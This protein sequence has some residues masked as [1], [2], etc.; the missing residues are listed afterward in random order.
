MVPA[1]EKEKGDQDLW[2]SLFDQESHLSPFAAMLVVQR[3]A[4]EERPALAMVDLKEAVPMGRSGPQMQSVRA[5]Y[6]VKA[7]S[8]WEQVVPQYHDC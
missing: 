1:L 2:Q 6:T 7:V 8:E 3:V 5:G 4:N